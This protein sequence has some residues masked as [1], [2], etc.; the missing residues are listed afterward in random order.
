MNRRRT[1]A[2]QLAWR[3]VAAWTAG[4]VRHKGNIPPRLLWVLLAVGAV[5]L[6]SVLLRV[7]A[8]PGMLG[9]GMAG[10]FEPIRALGSSLNEF[11]SLT[12]VPPESRDRILYL[13]YLPFSA[14]VIAIVRLT[15]GIRI[16]G[17]RSILI[18]V[19]FQQS[20]IVPSLILIGVVTGSI[21][22]L[23]PHLKR[24]RLPRYARISVILG[25][26]VILMVSALLL[27]PWLRLDMFWNV[28]FFP[29]LVLG[30]L[31]EGIARTLDKQNLL[32][33][34]WR[35][36]T[37]VFVG[38]GLALLFELDAVREILLQFPELV[39]T[40]IVAI[41]FVAEFL[42]L[43]LLEDWDSRLAGMALPQ[44][45]ANQHGH[46]VA[47][48][49]N[50]DT[51]GV[52]G[53]LGRAVP[54]KHLQRS[55]RPLVLGLRSGGHTV[56]VLEG[57]ISLLSELRDFIP[58]HPR[59]GK[60]GGIVFNLA[61]GI[62]GESRYA[63]VPAQ[64]EMA[65]IPYTGAS[66]LG[67]ALASDKVAMKI[68]L[69]QAGI[70]TPRGCSAMRDADVP[71]DLPYPC[72]VKPRYE[73][74]SPLQL[75]HGRGACRQAVRAIVR[76][77]KQPAVV[78]EYIEGRQFNVGLIGNDPVRPLPLVE[79]SIQTRKKTCPA[80]IDEALAQRIWQVAVA[81]FAAGGCRDYARVDVRV[82][83]AGEL[84]VCDVLTMGILERGGPFMH[85]AEA[86]GYN[87]SSLVCRI[88]KLARARYVTEPGAV[89]LTVQKT[90]RRRR[91]R[92]GKGAADKSAATSDAP[93][94]AAAAHLNVIEGGK[95]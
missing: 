48:V 14:L 36:V 34:A 72:I 10:A 24:A 21:A 55:I 20:G 4:A 46:R 9:S 8:L 16:L 90:K 77:Y 28:A 5:P 39:L 89:P 62:Q 18:A 38:L 30:L 13:L 47:V 68:A 27:G 57:D 45:F 67:C 53:R 75:V 94:G 12:S 3:T 41:V 26:V 49:R 29:V 92:N 58:A 81:A 42:D 44:L 78:E 59:T 86:A 74:R 61:H 66:V 35:A 80:R 54:G 60:P 64:L 65:G 17:F 23:R 51:Q 87:M 50:R 70:P 43:R 32:S 22:L 6:A 33:A 84:Q 91:R 2:R 76:R 40:T 63:H 73:P 15:L 88:V 37:T 82:S 31:A 69:A 85:A 71:E 93:R 25:V 52:I 19:G 95:G 11:L 83:P 56:K 1:S 7:A 79:W